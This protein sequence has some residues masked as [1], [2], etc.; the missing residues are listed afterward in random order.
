MLKSGGSINLAS[1]T[2]AE[3]D[4]G[5]CLDEQH[6]ATESGVSAASG[7]APGV[8]P[9]FGVVED[10]G[11]LGCVVQQAV[12]R[13]GERQALKGQLIPVV[14]SVKRAQLGQGSPHARSARATVKPRCVEGL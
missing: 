11:N 5:R 1:V 8:L 6:V 10:L 3:A 13:G 12:G 4:A 14:V 2:V 9:A 7:P